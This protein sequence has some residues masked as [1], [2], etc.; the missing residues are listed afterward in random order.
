MQLPEPQSKSLSSLLDGIKHGRIRIPQFQRKFVWDLKKSAELIDSILKGYPIGTFI[1]WQTQD[2]SLAVRSIDNKPLAK[3]AQ[4]TPIDLVLDGQ[5]RLASLYA[6]FKGLTIQRADNS[7]ADNFNDIVVNL[8]AAEGEPVVSVQ[9]DSSLLNGQHHVSP[10]ELNEGTLQDLNRFPNE[11]HGKISE[12]QK[13]ITGYNYSVVQFSDAPIEVATE[14]FT[15]I[16]TKGKV[17][18][19]FEIMVAKTYDKN[20]GFDLLEKWK[21][22]QPSLKQAGYET[23][24][25]EVVLRTVALITDGKYAKTHLLNMDKNKFIDNWDKATGAIE[26]AV[27]YLHISCR[28][29]GSILPYPALV[30]SYAYFFSRCAESSPNGK[31]AKFLE[32]FFWRVALTN[33]YRDGANVKAC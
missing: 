3:V 33:R 8:S 4:G 19:L 16:N 6:C 25:A 9:K 27:D 24:S 22:L 2:R 26:R 30:A 31:Q 15:R 20:R 32:D 10:K 1:F 29:P 13:I 28:I 17:L 7:Q 18:G 14:M 11:F 12:Y 5:Q 21:N 23:V